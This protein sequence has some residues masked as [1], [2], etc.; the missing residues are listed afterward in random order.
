M[1]PASGSTGP[2]EVDN[3]RFEARVA[4]PAAFGTSPMGC[5]VVRIRQPYR[6]L[7]ADRLEE[8]RMRDADKRSDPYV[9]GCECQSG[10]GMGD[11][12]RSRPR[13]SGGTPYRPARASGLGDRRL[14]RIAAHKGAVL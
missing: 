7:G 14:A 5:D 12:R 2:G 13:A 3:R 8:T 6:L 1:L 4:L 10:L 9:A 11:E